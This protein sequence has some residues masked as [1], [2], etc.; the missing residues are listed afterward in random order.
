MRRFLS[1]A[2]VATALV[3][4]PAGTSAGEGPDP[5]GVPALQAQVEILESL[6]TDLTAQV[7]VLQA[8]GAAQ[9]TAIND[10][11]AQMT[12]LTADQAAQ[13]T[14]VDHTGQGEASPEANRHHS[15]WRCRF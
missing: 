14:E 4:V 15:A 12:V 7:T 9:Q 6:N 13:L 1:L 11:T 2:L 8:E 10:L 5:G 3:V